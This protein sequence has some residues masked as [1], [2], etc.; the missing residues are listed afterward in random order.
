MDIM[1]LGS[2][3]LGVIGQELDWLA[4]WTAFG[5]IQSAGIQLVVETAVVD[6][7]SAISH[8]MILSGNRSDERAVDFE[9][10]IR[11]KSSDSTAQSSKRSEKVGGTHK[12]K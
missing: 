10:A 2:S 12:S 8:R 11:H 3:E 5:C 6:G 4:G 7:V 9:T 1:V